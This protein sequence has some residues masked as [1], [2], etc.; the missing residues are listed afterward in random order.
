MNI[1]EINR[2]RGQHG[3]DMFIWEVLTR[4]FAGVECSVE[5]NLMCVVTVRNPSVEGHRS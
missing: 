4:S 5:V 3:Y 2:S 1:G